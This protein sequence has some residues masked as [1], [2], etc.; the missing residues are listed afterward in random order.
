[1]T[2]GNTGA[3]AGR[4]VCHAIWA[5]DGPALADFYAAALGVT[6]TE[7]CP[8]EGG[9][10]T[11][12]GF[13]VNGAMYLLHTS[14]S[15]TPPRS[16]RPRPRWPEEELPFHMDLAF[17]DVAAAELRLLE[18]GATRPGHQ[19]GGKHWTV[20]LDPSG[21]PLCVHPDH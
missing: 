12:C 18:L 14:P 11:A 6:V 17:D 7:T 9:A 3:I 10:Q 1:M 21:Q 20:P 16:R 4:G 13:Y 2:N 5:P 8:D 19:P 15:F